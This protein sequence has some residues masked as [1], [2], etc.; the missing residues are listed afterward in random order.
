MQGF[1]K[2]WSVLFTGLAFV[3]ASGTSYGQGEKTPATPAKSDQP[4]MPT[5]AEV[6]ALTVFPASVS[7]KGLDD[8]AQLVITGQLTNGNTY[9][10]TGANTVGARRAR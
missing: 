8:S 9:T 7:L 10:I 6:S 3:A 4:V 1:R 5:P 2:T